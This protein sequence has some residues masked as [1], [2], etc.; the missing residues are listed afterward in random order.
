MNLF[1]KIECSTPANKQ[2]SDVTT[3][4]RNLLLPYINY[5][6]I[7]CQQANADSAKAKQISGSKYWQ[8]FLFHIR[9]ELSVYFYGLDKV[10]KDVSMSAFVHVVNECTFSIRNPKLLVEGTIVNTMISYVVHAF[11]LPDNQPDARLDKDG[12]T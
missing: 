1:S 7:V 9:F 10:L 4:R 12:K 2:F 11:Q 5:V 3:S 8:S 6:P